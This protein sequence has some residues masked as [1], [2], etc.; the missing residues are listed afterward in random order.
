MSLS[1]QSDEIVTCCICL[2]NVG[3]DEY[4]KYWSCNGP[5]ADV[6]CKTCTLELMI[7]S[8]SCPLCRAENS[9]SI[10]SIKNLNYYFLNNNINDSDIIN[11]I[12]L[13]IFTRDIYHEL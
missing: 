7:N 1:I 11:V 4:K 13:L 12:T 2:D 10:I 9:F 3:S 5:H 6:I 8:S